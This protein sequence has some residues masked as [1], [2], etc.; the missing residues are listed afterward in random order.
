VTDT[1]DGTKAAEAPEP[2]TA[3]ADLEA[4][5]GEQVADAEAQGLLEPSASTE[6]ELAGESDADETAPA[7]KRRRS[8]NRGRHR[9][10]SADAGSEG[11]EGDS[12]AEEPNGKQA[13]R[14]PEPALPATY[15]TLE[16]AF[17]DLDKTV[18]AKASMVAFGRPFYHGGLINKRTVLRALYAELVYLHLGA[19]EQ[20]LNQIRESVLRLIRGWHSDRVREIVAE[21]IEGIVEP[22][23]YAEA[24]DLID[25]H[26]EHGRLVVIV[27]AS[28]EEIVAPLSRFL[29]A[30]E[31]IASQA[32]VDEEGRYTGTMQ[33]YAFGPF[34][35]EA[36]DA[37][38]AERGIDLAA[39]Y[40]YTDSYTDLPMLEAV[41]HPVAVNPDRVLNRYAREHDFEVL[42]FSQTVSLWNR[43]RDRFGTVPPRPAIAASAGAVVLGMVAAVAGWWL[44]SRR[45]DS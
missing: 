26:H 20:K 33:F 42:H 1:P 28:P 29:G 36:M 39:S 16:A 10:D 27:S 25:F 13:V 32:R 14:K 8:R 43:V 34:K 2:E 21:A 37:L 23:I 6:L 24:A 9:R 4:P 17:F 7:T 3:Q 31:F 30:D 22:I 45:H 12:G 5:G 15:G 38:A 40:A 44:G 11:G 18:I 35:A 19:S 41:G